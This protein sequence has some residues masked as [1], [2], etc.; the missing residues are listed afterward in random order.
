MDHS[1]DIL[2]ALIPAAFL[3]D[4]IIGDPA[5][6][7]H[8]IRIIGNGIIAPTERLLRRLALDGRG[9]GLILLIA[10]LGISSGFVVLLKD[11]LWPYPLVYATVNLYW[12]YSCIAVKDLRRHTEGLDASAV[13]CLMGFTAVR[14]GVVQAGL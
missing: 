2:S 7:C 13:I 14:C 12:L 1:V 8:P 5:Y 3:L 11:L 10:T 4:L 9:G 6:P